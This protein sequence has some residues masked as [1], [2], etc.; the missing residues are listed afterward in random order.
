VKPGIVIGATDKDSNA[1][2]ADPVSV[3]DILRTLFHQ[4][5]IDSSK[6]YNTPL[7]RPVPIVNGGRVIKDLVR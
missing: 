5:G 6:V 2:V 4:L 7:G 1:P 3:E